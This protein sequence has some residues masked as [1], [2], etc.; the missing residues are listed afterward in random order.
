MNGGDK[1]TEQEKGRIYTGFSP[2]DYEKIYDNVE[3]EIQ[4]ER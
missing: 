2:K 1:G 4:H 3:L